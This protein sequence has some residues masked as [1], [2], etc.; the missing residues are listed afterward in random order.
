MHDRTS[1]NRTMIAS[2]LFA[3]MFWVHAIKCFHTHEQDSHY[4]HYSA[5]TFIEDNGHHACNICEFQPA[6]DADFTTGIGFKH[7]LPPVTLS[8][9]QLQNSYI[10][11]CYLSGDTRGPP[12]A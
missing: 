9:C 11:E 7:Y 3:V 1:S 10:A 6:K 12:T 5:I 2:L 8:C 4:H